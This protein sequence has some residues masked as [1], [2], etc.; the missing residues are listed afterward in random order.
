VGRQRVSPASE[1]LVGGELMAAGGELL[2]HAF[3]ALS[4]LA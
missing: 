2:I 1:A 4:A 3:E